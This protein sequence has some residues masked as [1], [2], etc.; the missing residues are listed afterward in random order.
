M[1]ISGSLFNKSIVYQTMNT[2]IF[3]IGGRLSVSSSK[4]EMYLRRKGAGDVK[5]S[6][7]R[8]VTHLVVPDPENLDRDSSKVQAALKRNVTIV[9]EEWCRELPAETPA[10]MLGFKVTL[11]KNYKDQNVDGW[12]CSEK[13]DGVRA[14][15][16]GVNRCFWSRAG[17]LIHAPSEFVEEFPDV[18]LDG[19]LYGG[20]GNFSRTSGIVRTKEPSYEQW[21]GLHFCV[22]DT[23]EMPKQPFE[24]RQ[25]YL[26][27]LIQDQRHLHLCTQVCIQKTTI[28]QRLAEIISEG[29]E[30]L[31]LRKPGSKYEFKRTSSLL[32]VKEMHDAEAVVIGYESGTGKYRGLCGSLMC[33]Y[34]GK[35]FK[36]GSGLSD[37]NRRNPPKIGQKITFGYFEM[38][39]S[40]IPR[41]PT[42]KRVFQG[43]V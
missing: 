43:R 6:V 30:G 9:S 18:T 33:E 17:N 32:K 36:C 19:E 34:R 5:K 20:R 21:Q 14:V 37:A 10:P 24:T 38:S 41:F 35:M 11:A 22:F 8:N 25:K 12:W 4:F 42:F 27:G 31:M 26:S 39:E 40:N 1:K 13:L 3:C 16:D 28:P 15:W 29:G 2:M 23:P 7:T